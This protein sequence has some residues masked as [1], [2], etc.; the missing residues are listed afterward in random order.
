MM[1]KIEI[2]KM[3]KNTKIDKCGCEFD[4]ELCEYKW[5]YLEEYERIKPEGRPRRLTHREF[6]ELE[7]E[8]I[9]LCTLTNV[10]ELTSDEKKR[11]EKL[12]RLL[13]AD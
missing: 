4:E 12:G 2:V 9:D 13:L 11:M 1:Q 10:R 8:M 7:G 3:P 6:H 5:S